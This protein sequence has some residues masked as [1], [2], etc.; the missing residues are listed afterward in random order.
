MSINDSKP[1]TF[2]PNKYPFTFSRGHLKDFLRESEIFIDHI[3]SKVDE[4]PQPWKSIWATWKT[5]GYAKATSRRKIATIVLESKYICNENVKTTQLKVINKIKSTI[6]FAKDLIGFTKD[7]KDDELWNIMFADEE[8]IRR[9]YNINEE[10]N[11]NLNEEPDINEFTNTATD[12]DI[13][14]ENTQNDGNHDGSEW[15]DIVNK[16]NKGKS[17]VAKLI[18]PPTNNDDEPLN[19]PLQSNPFNILRTDTTQNDQDDEDQFLSYD[20]DI[21]DRR[22]AQQGDE[23]L[24]PSSTQSPSQ[25]RQQRSDK[26]SSQFFGS[27]SS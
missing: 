12:Q 8:S 13:V 9:Y 19:E 17:K 2:N 14:P 3:I 24:T 27:N 6:P 25:W 18:A 16:K 11:I 23:E 4:G 21:D 1:I 22:G 5:K 15:T 7:D 10:P 20:D 26:H